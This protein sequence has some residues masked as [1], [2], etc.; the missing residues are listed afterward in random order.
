[1]P[2][3]TALS[4]HY[5]SSQKTPIAFRLPYCIWRYQQRED[6]DSERNEADHRVGGPGRLGQRSGMSLEQI[7]ML[8]VVASPS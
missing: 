1:M 7:D 4:W 5:R 8:N 2:G 6:E 3:A